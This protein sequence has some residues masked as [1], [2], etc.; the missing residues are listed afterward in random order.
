LNHS[1]IQDGFSIV[2]GLLAE[3]AVEQLIAFVEQTM[4][5]N[6][7]RGGVRNLLDV[8]V[9]QNLAESSLL[10]DQAKVVLGSRA[11]VVRGILFDKTENANWK[12]PWHQDVTI[13][14]NRRVE[15]DGFGPWSVKEGVLHVQPPASVL[16][17]MVSIRL[18][19]DD[20]PVEN[21]ALRVIPGSHLKGKLRER[22]IQE[23]AEQSEEFTCA[24]RRGGVLIM[25]PLLVHA[26]SAASVPGHRRVLHF[27]YAAASL[28]AEIDWA[29]S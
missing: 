9:M 26:S 13:A 2:E 10:S 21:G 8:S 4:C 3:S 25:R 16:E 23:I 15:A 27:D 19:L 6:G 1:I 5:S 17:E 20:C 11:R 29:V 12:V 14:V 18:H 24:I 22:V 28:P 7:R